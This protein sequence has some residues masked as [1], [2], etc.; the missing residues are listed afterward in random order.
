MKV[1]LFYQVIPNLESVL[2]GFTSD[3]LRAAI[4][5]LY[6]PKLKQ[7]IKDVPK[8][9]YNEMR[10]KLRGKEIIPHEFETRNDH[11]G[12]KKV[13]QI[14]TE[15]EVMNII[16]HKEELALKELSKYTL[17]IE[18]FSSD[19]RKDLRRVY[20]DTVNRYCEEVV[21]YPGDIKNIPELN[22]K[23][24]ELGLFVQLYGHLMTH[25]TKKEKKGT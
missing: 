16:L 9:D 5:R 14:A 25:E 15:H 20:M 12:S 10:D 11:F 1:Y 6:R 2:Y 24:D 22:F 23:I 4:F 18:I 7:I 19:M 8:K 3:K 17:P 13:S 21:V